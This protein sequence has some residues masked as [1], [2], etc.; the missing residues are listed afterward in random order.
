MKT[1]LIASII[2]AL[3][4]LGALGAPVSDTAETPDATDAGFL[5]TCSNTSV[6]IPN[7]TLT[8]TCRARNG[9]QITSTISLDSC[10]GNNVGHL[11]AQ[12]NG[13]FSATCPGIFFLG[14][15]GTIATLTTTCSDGTTVTPVTSSLDLN[16][17]ISNIDG[18]LTCP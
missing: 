2:V 4:A 9:N 10:I 15:D 18:T 8:S 1:S 7:V 14:G 11:V 6:D 5:F 17:V 16:T 12:V 3:G 13:D